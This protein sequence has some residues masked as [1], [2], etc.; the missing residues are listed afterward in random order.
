MPIF[1]DDQGQWWA[2]YPLKT[3]RL[4]RKRLEAGKC[5]RCGKEFGKFLSKGEKQTRFCSRT[6]ANHRGRK[7]HMTSGYRAI[8]P[9]V[10]RPEH[11][12]TYYI[13]EHRLV[14]EELLGRGLTRDET[15][16]H[17]NGIR[18]DNRPEN[19]ELWAGRHPPGMR[20]KDLI[21]WAKWILKTY[22][23]EKNI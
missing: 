7:V 20:V 18:T 1:K 13:M 16:H 12:S 19:L 8:A 21:E 2:V 23:N 22:E 17:K 15:V 5:Q 6:C 3:G 4:K 9:G 11:G 14:M 10:R